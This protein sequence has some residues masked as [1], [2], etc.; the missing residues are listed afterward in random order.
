MN[1]EIIED[2][3]ISNGREFETSN[4]DH[5]MIQPSV[6]EVIRVIKGVPLF[7]EDHMVRLQRSAESLDSNLT[8]IIPNITADIKRLIQLNHQPEKNIKLIVYNLEKD[9]PDYIMCF[10]KSSYPSED[11]YFQGIHTI[12]VHA[13]RDNPNA[14]IINNELRVMINQKLKEC[15]AYEALL[16]NSRGEITEG[17]RSNLF[18]LVHGKIYTS[19]AEDVLIGITRKYI[20]EACRSLNLE[21]IEQ[22]IPFSMLD[23]AEG[24]FIT[25]TSPKLLPI[26][27]IEEHQLDSANNE[28]VKSVRIEYDRI[29][30]KYI[31][32]H[33]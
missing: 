26:A 8:E 5:Q 16:L 19:P 4:F 7:I 28:I 2:Y 24:A 32:E 33:K 17:S 15:N 9:I 23:Y 11:Q 1:K 31:N 22:P 6:Y 10:I 3:F 18:F 29:L 21:I 20:I 13:E 25:G 30:E 14:K 12:L 27:S